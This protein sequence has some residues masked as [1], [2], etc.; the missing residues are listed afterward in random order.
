MKKE[1]KHKKRKRG[2]VPKIVDKPVENVENISQV[3]TDDSFEKTIQESKDAI[4]NEAIKNVKRG[5]GRPPKDASPNA[6][7]PLGTAPNQSAIKPPTPMPK[8]AV[9]LAPPLQAL[10]QIPAQKHGIP[11]LAFDTN[12]ATLIADS[13]DNLLT[14]FIPDLN[15]MSP[16]TAAIFTFAITVSSVGFQKYNIYQNVMHERYK[17]S[18]Q[19]EE[20]QNNVVQ[21]EPVKGPPIEADDYFKKQ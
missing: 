18:V 15:N 14:V 20:S 5:R 6:S 19:K 7:S 10:S 8:L 16:K 9:Y 21:D 3:P 13:L 17:N 2:P 4:H 12:E 1:L 11:E